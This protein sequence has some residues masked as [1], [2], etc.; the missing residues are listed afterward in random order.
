M[1]SARLPQDT[2]AR[3]AALAEERNQSKSYI[4]QKALAFYLAEEYSEKDS[5][6][7]GEDYFGRYGS[8]DGNL[9]KDYKKRLREKLHA[10]HHSH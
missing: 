5:Y 1:T 8:G 10:K 2:E 4:I 3:L 9:S 7:L 6:K